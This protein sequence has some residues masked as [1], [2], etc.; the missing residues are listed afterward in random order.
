M[1]KSLEK[2]MANTPT[3]RPVHVEMRGKKRPALRLPGSPKTEQLS[4]KDKE[5]INPDRRTSQANSLMICN[6][7][8]H[9]LFR[10]YPFQGVR[11]RMLN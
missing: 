4:G 5:I 6:F 1:R 2:E 7:A 9:S 3:E 11:S 10:L 8:R